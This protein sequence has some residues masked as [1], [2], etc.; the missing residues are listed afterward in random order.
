MNKSV[1]P[2]IQLF[3]VALIYGANYSIAKSIMPDWLTPN[4]FIFIRIASGTFAFWVIAY[5]MRINES[6]AKSDFPRLIFCGLTGTA[7]NQ[8]FF[9]KGL[10]YT[11]SVNASVIMTLSPILVLIIS[12]IVLRTKIT[13]IKI[14]GIIIG[15]IGAA[16]LMGQKN[17]DISNESFLGD[18]FILINASSYA[19][20]LVMV[21]P[22][23]V[24]YNAMTV[25]KWVFTFGL[26]FI[27]PF[28]LIDTL[29][30]N[31]SIMPPTVLLRV[32]YVVICTTI[33]AYMLNL[34]AMKKVNPS[35]VGAYIY[36]QPVC[37][38]IISVLILNNSLSIEKIL[39]S[40]LIFVGVYMV[41]QPKLSRKAA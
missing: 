14:T 32:G 7:I 2:H 6:V 25:V 27:T 21:K 31:F 36:L 12:A 28:G 34:L 5:L 24:K 16:L 26:I 11:S 29:Q 8:L 40:I 19:F 3:I 10:V 23:M 33:L 30:T 22:L 39:Y 1:I 4:A 38:M 9:F 20:Y 41:S 35:V 15:A 18:L 37:A 17:F 13:A